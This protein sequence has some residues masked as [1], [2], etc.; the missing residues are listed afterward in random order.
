[1]PWVTKD[2]GQHIF[3]NDDGTVSGAPA[4]D[5]PKAVAGTGQGITPVAQLHTPASMGASGTVHTSPEVKRM[6]AP[7]SLEPDY[8]KSF[9]PDAV[10][11]R[12]D[13]RPVMS[14][15]RFD[16]GD[17]SSTARFARSAGRWELQTD[18][19]T[20]Q[21]FADANKALREG[22]AAG[23]SPQAAME[24]AWGKF[25]QGQPL[26]AGLQKIVRRE[27]KA[28]KDRVKQEAESKKAWLSQRMGWRDKNPVL[29]QEHSIKYEVRGSDNTTG[30][31]SLVNHN[32]RVYAIDKP[33]YRSHTSFPE[34]P[35]L[36]YD[37]E[38]VRVGYALAHGQTTYEQLK[39]EG[40]TL[41]DVG[42]SEGIRHRGGQYA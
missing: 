5:A 21:R 26:P 24:G 29:W 25:S 31:L 4:K 28:E 2:D 33:D 17:N 12:P 8:I 38:E 3:I 13:N 40:L 9:F 18:G 36:K 32:G 34:N 10:K 11:S 41:I 15:S 16:E 20:A 30:T 7:I 23:L 1:M 19:A 35:N 14:M 22:K 39:R 27:V 6:S 37:S 42:S